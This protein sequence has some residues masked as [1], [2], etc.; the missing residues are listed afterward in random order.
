MQPVP[1]PPSLPVPSPGNPPAEAGET[2]PGSA[3]HLARVF[4]QI[5]AALA[6]LVAHAF[7]KD[8]RRVALIVPL[9]GYLTRT[10]RRFDRLIA[11]LAAGRPPR[12]A[13]PA[14]TGRPPKSAKA[15]EPRQPGSRPRL[16]RGR[17]WLA[18][19]LQHHGAGYA[20]QLNHL[21]E[22]PANAA[23]L[24]ASPQAQRLLRPLCHILGIAPSCV[25]PLPP[26][27]RKPRPKPVPKPRPLTRKQREAIL[28]YPNSEG[29]PMKL[30]PPRKFAR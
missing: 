20:S 6:A 5:I 9:W 29:R 22:D 12:A 4:G 25:P 15:A 17:R 14:R 26:R 24:T 10:A 19:A 8:P 1:T 21:L 13:R 11:R 30:L 18:A 7:L 2:V 3:P 27:P 23:L 28:W 16:P